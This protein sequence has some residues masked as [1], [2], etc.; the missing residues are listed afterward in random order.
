MNNN[1]DMDTALAKAWRREVDAEIVQVEEVLRRAAA[2][3]NTLPHEEDTLLKMIDETSRELSD[4]WERLI[5]TF[6][7]V[8]EITKGIVQKV[9]ETGEYGKEAIEEFRKSLNI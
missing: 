9:V 7:E 3:L 2:E 1:I 6:N 8:E 4:K 5:A